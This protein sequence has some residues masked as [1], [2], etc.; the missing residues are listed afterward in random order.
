MPKDETTRGCE[1]EYAYFEEIL[2]FLRVYHEEMTRKKTETDELVKYSLAHY[3]SDNSEQFVELVLNMDNQEAYTKKAAETAYA[4]SKPYFARIDFIPDDAESPQK[5]YIG[6]M[7]LMRGLDIL[8]TDWRAPIASLYYEGRLG[9]ASYDCPDGNILGELTLKRQYAID[10]GRLGSIT[11]IDITTNDE[12][13]QAALGASK[14][15][16]LKDIVQTIQA[17]QNKIIRAPLYEPLIVQGVAGGGKTTIALHRIAYLLYAYEKKLSPRQV[18]ILAPNRLFLSYISE[19]LPDLG[20]ERVKQSVF[21]EFAAECVGLPKK[22]TV[23]PSIRTTADYIEARALNQTRQVELEAGGGLDEAFEAMRAAEF[24]SRLSFMELVERFVEQIEVCLCPDKDFLLDD[25]ELFTHEALG[26]LFM[27]EYAYLPIAVRAREI[28]KHLTNTL[29]KEKPL[30]LDSI[31]AGCDN[32]RESLKRRMPEDT[33]ERRRLISEMLD[34][35]D[36]RMARVKNQSKVI[37]ERYMRRFKVAPVIELYTRLLSEPGLLE[38]FGRGLFAP[39]ELALLAGYT[40][41]RLS[42]FKL[43]T[44]DLPPLLLMQVRLFGAEDEVDVKHIVVDEAQDL[45]LFQLAALKRLVPGASFSVLGDLHQGIMSHKGIRSWDE[46]IE[47]ILPKGRYMTLEQSYRTTVEIMEAANP[48]IMKLYKGAEPAVPIAVPV[49]RRGKPVAML[50]TADFA[51]AARQIDKK[52][53]GFRESGRRSIAVI[54]KTAE[55]CKKTLKA[56]KNKP[57]LLDARETDYAGG[58]IIL[59]SYLA[60]GFEFDAVIIADASSG[61]YGD[62]ELDI[63]LLYIAMTRALHELALFSVGKKSSLVSHISP[64]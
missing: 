37:I 17:E 34:D 32:R 61:R 6:K 58:A 23:R 50:E 31:D 25:Y 10:N 36:A 18:M 15:M 5:N 12:F 20:V 62:D 11:D 2:A 3:N 52:I 27:R 49:I 43:D 48:V 40:R 42:R 51:E 46:T 57:R 45:S 56:L 44:E 24:K 63:K 64:A 19:V 39:D 8:I 53:N 30:I 13:L 38:D 60:K 7:N 4:L 54:C 16:R 14:D 22:W 28:R 21:E 59:P 41:R 55:D 35:R 29:K 33:P 1:D 47:K 9:R 26:D